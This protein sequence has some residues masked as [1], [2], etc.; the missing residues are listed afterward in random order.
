MRALL[1]FIAA[2]VLCGLLLARLTGR[3]REGLRWLALGGL[4]GPLMLFAATRARR[5]IH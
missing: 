5:G 1:A 3:S 2:W 4:L